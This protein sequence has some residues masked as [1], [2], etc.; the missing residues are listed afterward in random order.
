M[1]DNDDEFGI[2]GYREDF[3]YVY[4]MNKIIVNRYKRAQTEDNPADGDFMGLSSSESNIKFIGEIDVNVNSINLR[5]KDVEESGRNMAGLRI[6]SGIVPH[7]SE[8]NN[9]DIIEF[10][11]NNLKSNVTK[12]EKFVVNL[13][14]VGPLKGQFC[15]KK[16]EAFSLGD[17][18]NI[19][20]LI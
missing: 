6:L 18:Q 8:L 1:Y 19:S 3:K 17:E 5:K 15:F 11:N 4:E 14:D 20:E 13:A 7:D 10:I 12:G 2:D 9:G 16:F